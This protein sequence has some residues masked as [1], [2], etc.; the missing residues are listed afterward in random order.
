MLIPSNKR[1]ARI[2]GS[3][4]EKL[5]LQTPSNLNRPSRLGSKAAGQP[6]GFNYIPPMDVTTDNLL[7]LGGGS[8][9]T[10]QPLG[11]N[12]PETQQGVKKRPQ[13]GGAAIIGK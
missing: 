11:P 2:L 10:P 3:P 8:P 7:S 13:Q 6:L 12:T 5:G 9:T 4:D 1:E